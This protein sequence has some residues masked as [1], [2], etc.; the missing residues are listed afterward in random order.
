[1]SVKVDPGEFAP[2]FGALIAPLSEG[3]ASSIPTFAFIDPFGY[4][5]ASMALTGGLLDFPRCEVL[6]F[7][8]L[9]HIHRFVSRKG[10]E[11]AMMSLFDTEEWRDAITM[12]GDERR[13]F[14]I[15]LFE[16]QLGKRTGVKHVRSFQ[17]RTG[18]GN[19]YR[20][21]FGLGHKKGLALAKDAMWSVD[22]VS[23]TSY[24]ASTG[25]GQEVLVASQF[26]DTS[27]L[28]GELKQKFGTDW[29]TIDQAEECTLLETPFR[30]GHLRQR[31][32]APAEREGHLEVE[33]TGRSG[34]KHARMRF[35]G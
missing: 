22:P 30:T 14:L 15:G 17:I 19:D 32:L 11:A 1:V 18:D 31:T 10:Q 8:P 25:S 3:G 24:S 13:E 34:F 7:L 23:G 20:L 4:S 26:V 21:V 16:R 29:F 28:L 2:T 12:D 6:F 35:L 9:S 27:A 5:T 33:R